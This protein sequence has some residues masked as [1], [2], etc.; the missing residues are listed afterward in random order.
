ML[1]ASHDEQI[2]IS[3]LLPRVALQLRRCG[4]SAPSSTVAGRSGKKSK[5]KRDDGSRNW[6]KVSPTD[7][8]LFITGVNFRAPL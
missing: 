5:K 1:I 2:R 6:P 4:A 3:R 8:N 7:A